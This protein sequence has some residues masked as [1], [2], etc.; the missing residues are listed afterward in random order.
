MFSLRWDY[1]LV[2][3]HQ[4]ELGRR[5]RHSRRG[6]C[7]NIA[8]YQLCSPPTRTARVCTAGCVV[9][10]PVRFVPERG[11]RNESV[12]ALLPGGD[13][14]RHRS[15]GEAVPRPPFVLTPDQPQRE[16][17]STRAINAVV[18][19]A[20]R[21]PLHASTSQLIATFPFVK[22]RP[23]YSTVG[24]THSNRAIYALASTDLKAGKANGAAV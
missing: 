4:R 18:L 1:T 22:P 15:R 12:P 14:K 8:T 13:R 21:L 6:W 24:I 20:M 23:V 9:L 3:T 19:W 2:C 7:F 11:E 17:P 16:C 10:D 5:Q